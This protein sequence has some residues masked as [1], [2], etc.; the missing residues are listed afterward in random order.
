MD[1]M[2]KKD[3]VSALTECIKINKEYEERIQKLTSRL[4]ILEAKI[5]KLE[6]EKVETKK[7]ERVT[8]KLVG[9]NFRSDEVKEFIYNLNN[10]ISCELISEKDNKFDK[11]AIKVMHDDKHLGYIPKSF[12]RSI[13]NK[14]NKVVSVELFPCESEYEKKLIISF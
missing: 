9:I 10:P 7:S 4:E 12:N 11:N 1:K 3:L 2:L 5:E 14:L 8:T 6:S 13:I